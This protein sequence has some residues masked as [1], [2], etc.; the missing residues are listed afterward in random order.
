MLLDLA[1]AVG[2]AQ[3]DGKPPVFEIHIRDGQGHVI[4]HSSGPEREQNGE[5]EA[6]PVPECPVCHLTLHEL[7]DSGRFG[8][9]KCYEVFR[10]EVP[11][12]TRELQY[13][14]RHVGRVPAAIA[15][16]EEVRRLQ[17]RLRKALSRQRYEDA[18]ALADRI[19]GLGGTPSGPS[20]DDP[21]AEKR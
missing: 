15:K 10:D 7:R 19:R 16:A 6:E 9:P 4:H 20:E 8:C 17:K 21:H 1:N 5:V 14:D 2:A 13:D 11:V 18:T 12:F 3:R